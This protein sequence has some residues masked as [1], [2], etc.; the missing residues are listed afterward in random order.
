M[1]KIYLMFSYIGWAWTIIVLLA[2][3]LWSWLQPWM[4][5]RKENARG[6]EIVKPNE[7]QH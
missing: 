3:V 1:M 4:R 6:F 2:L 5:N 7:K